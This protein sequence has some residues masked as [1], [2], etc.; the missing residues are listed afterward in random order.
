ML[1]YIAL[2]VVVTLAFAYLIVRPIV[3][4]FLDPKGLRKYPNYALLSGITDFRHC[5]TS[6]QGFRSRSLY[7]AHQKTGEPIL[8][9]GPNSL[10]FGDTRAV[11]AIYGHNTKCVKDNNYVVL[12]GS[13][14]HLFDVVDKPDHSRKR[15]LLSA[16]FAIKNLE[17]WEYKVAYTAKRLFDA[18]DKK[19]TAPLKGSIPDLQDVNLDFSHWINLWTTEAICY[20][21]LSAKMDLLDTG[22]DEVPAEKRDGTRYRGRYRDARDQN[23]L[24]QAVWVWDYNLW[25]W[26]KWLTKTMPGKYQ[27]MWD[28]AKAWDDIYYH[29]AAERL[30]RFEAGEELDDFFS[31][32]ME[33]KTGSPNNLEWGEIVS[34]I[35]AI[36]N[37]GSDTTA[38]ALTQTLELLIKHPQHL[39]H[40]RQELDSVLET[41]EAIAPYD[42]VKDLPF[43]KACIDES[44]RVIPPTSAGLPRRTPPE[45]AQILDQWIPG[46]TSVN[47]TIYAAHRD[48]KVFPNPETY[49]PMRWMDP[50]E[51]KRM[52]P[53]FIPFSTGA[54]GCIGRNI[55]Y[56]EQIVV[57]ASL[58]HRYDF[59]LPSS[60]FNM[61]RVEAFNIICGQLPIKIWRR[62]IA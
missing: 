44:L 10:S 54:R 50:N 41:D 29:Q 60:D 45:G 58:V 62:E 13:H 36:I 2:G 43:L 5:Y 11:K 49:N 55:S 26:V 47:M 48:P 33:D 57:L 38:I 25:P 27:K 3:V 14:R 17:K 18:F 1:G 39:Q 61:Q 34:E 30:R 46:D 37:A 22:T 32:L 21:T 56:L 8:R 4:Y 24:A 28:A 31:C 53:L 52:E 42:K 51:R 15:R 20:I 7:E 19:C 40:L 12:S 6:S 35:G 59:A 23:A 16:A 9:I